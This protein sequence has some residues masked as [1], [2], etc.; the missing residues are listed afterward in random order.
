MTTPNDRNTATFTTHGAS[1]FSFHL[2]GHNIVQTFPTPDHFP[3]HNTGYFGQTIG[4]VSNRVAGA[5]LHNLNGKTYDLPV[6]Q[7][8]GT[9]LHGGK[10]GWGKKEWNGPHTVQRH[11][12]D[13]SEFRYKS[14]DGDE[15]FPGTV[16]AKIWY[17]VTPTVD[18]KSAKEGIILDVEYEVLMPDSQSEGI[19]ETIV[20]VTNHSYFNLD[21]STSRET[22]TGHAIKLPSTLHL[23]VDASTQ[24]P[25]GAVEPFPGVPVNEPIQVTDTEPSIDHC[26]IVADR[27][28][29]ENAVPNARK[30]PLDTRGRELRKLVELR[31]KTDE[32]ERVLEVQSTEPAFQFFTGEAIDAPA[33][34]AA[35]GDGA[36]AGKEH[37]LAG[38]ARGKRAGF[39]IEPSR[40]VDC[41]SRE[42][43]R[44]M[45]RMRK[46]DVYGSRSRYVAWVE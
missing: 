33:I 21:P 28:D 32:G 23:P 45:C 39:A 8:G 16:E 24:I 25:T 40:Y 1:I 36:V 29:G 44:G 18:H 46:G 15:R 35:A 6:N 30:V 43:W 42:E 38:Q 27:A 11:G 4:R 22:I 12:R 13:A 14:Q 34:E 17:T 41:A 5:K 31:Y 2:A 20:A 19:E 3:T 10:Q 7:P 37:G 26:M 9:C